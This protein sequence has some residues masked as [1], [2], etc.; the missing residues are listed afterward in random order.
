MLIARVRKHERGLYF[1]HGD[2]VRLL[3]PG[4]VTLWGNLVKPGSVRVEVASTLVAMFVLSWELTALSLFM[5]PFFL[6]LTYKVGKARQEVASSTQK[7]LA[8]DHPQ[9]FQTLVERLEAV[10][11]RALFLPSQADERRQ[12]HDSV[13]TKAL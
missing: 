11:R 6:W 4:R 10:D 7:T 3:G 9:A 12:N 8:E 2:F 5:L 13:P 1:E